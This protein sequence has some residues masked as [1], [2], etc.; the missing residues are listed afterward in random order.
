MKRFRRCSVGALACA[1]LLLLGC[2]SHETKQA[3]PPRA[4]DAPRL[5]AELA[6][7]QRELDAASASMRRAVE[8]ASLAKDATANA[9]AAARAIEQRGQGA[10]AGEFHPIYLDLMSGAAAALRTF[11]LSV[12]TEAALVATRKQLDEA[13]AKEADQSKAI[14]ALEAQRDE[15]LAKLEAANS[16][17]DR[18]QD[19][20]R[21]AQ[22]AATTR[23]LFYGGL[24]AA[25]GIGLLIAVP[26][27][28]KIGWIIAIM[29]GALVVVAIF[30]SVAVSWIHE[31][32]WVVF[33]GLAAVGGF[34]LWKLGVLSWFTRKTVGAIEAAEP[35][36]AADTPG[37]VKDN[38]SKTLGAASGIATALVDATKAR[39]G[40]PVGKPAAEG[41][42]ATQG[43]KP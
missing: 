10:T 7:V 36:K 16:S 12:E 22:S 5:A 30:V 25:A 37:G 1:L 33:L 42:A 34:V 29:G 23:L 41:T 43:G 8:S 21:R 3:V 14:A 13:R 24:I 31:H 17:I 38:L 20:D 4:P 35:G 18:L 39:L 11:A 27:A 40:I 19:A 15:L 26:G 28:S 6:E 9:E 2:A 32:E